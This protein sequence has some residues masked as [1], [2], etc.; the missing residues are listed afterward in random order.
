MVCKAFI[1]FF[2]RNETASVPVEDQ[3]FTVWPVDDP[4]N[5]QVKNDDC[6]F[7]LDHY[8]LVASQLAM[9][10]ARK[11]KASFEGAGPYLVGWS[12]SRARGIPDA[13]VLVVDMSSDNNQADIDNKFRFWKTK[14]VENPSLWRNG[15]S[16]EGVRAAIHNFADQY[17]QAIL[18]A[19]KLIGDKKS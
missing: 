17:G 15:W 19:I 3:M 16:V 8:D 6:D 9:A 1:A 2:P 13:L 5:R 10:D 4:T 11:Q 12:P 7:V 14:I 18:D